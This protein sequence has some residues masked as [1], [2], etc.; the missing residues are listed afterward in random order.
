MY[1]KMNNPEFIVPYI[2]KQNP[3]TKKSIGCKSH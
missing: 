2:H 3:I 1:E